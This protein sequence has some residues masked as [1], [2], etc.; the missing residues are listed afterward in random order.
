MEFLCHHILVLTLLY[1]SAKSIYSQKRSLSFLLRDPLRN[2][3]PIKKKNNREKE[4]FECS[5]CDHMFRLSENEYENLKDEK[6]F[7]IR[8]IQVS[9]C[10]SKLK[11]LNCHIIS[12]MVLQTGVNL[13]RKRY[14]CS[15]KNV[16]PTDITNILKE[17]RKAKVTIADRCKTKVI[18]SNQTEL[19]HCGIFGDPHIKTFHDKRQTCVVEGLW[20]LLDNDHMKVQV[21]NEILQTTQSTSATAT[22]KVRVICI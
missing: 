19:L 1:S 22:T 8:L 13:K 12:V 2:E 3:E 6:K 20:T 4:Q 17:R 14:E 11:K 21:T 18:K 15:K 9:R 10:I 5:K 7:C 16:S